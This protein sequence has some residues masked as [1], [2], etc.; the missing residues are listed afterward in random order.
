MTWHLV[1]TDYPP[2]DGGIAS[3]AA[4][5]AAALKAAGEHVVVYVP[6]RVGARDAVGLWGRSWA[7]WAHLWVTGQVLPRVRSGD[8]VLCATWPLATA[9]LG[10]ADVSVAFHGSDLT[11]PPLVGGLDA[12]KAGARLYPVSAFLGGLLGAPH[13]VLPAA[14]G[15]EPM[16]ASGSHLLVIARLG[17]LKGVDRALRIAASCGRGVTIVGDGPEREALERL[18][19]D[20]GVRAQFTGRL[21]RA[22]IPWDGHHAALLLSR[23]DPDGSGAEGLGLVLLEAAA[24]GIPT[25]G[26]T[27]GGIPE[28]AMRVLPDGVDELPGF[29]AED[30]ER[31]VAFVRARHGP[32]RTVGVLRADLTGQRATGVEPA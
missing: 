17:P 28:A 14:I 22:D 13:T 29:D 5:T 21:A 12:I 20:L 26:S 15:P 1:T 18:V 27:T 6:R 9:L 25:V 3:W 8:R 23:A 2:L 30:R 10:R 11:R 32:E 16:A 24:R 31:A 7:R 4:N 19:G